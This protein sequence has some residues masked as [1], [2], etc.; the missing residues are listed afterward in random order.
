VAQYNLALAQGILFRSE[1]VTVHVREHVRSVVRFAKLL[2]LLCTYA[3][4]PKGTVLRV[5]GPLSLFRQTTK[6]GRA[7][8]SFLPSLLSTPG[9][10]IEAR[11]VLGDQKLR[12]LASA[13]DPLARPHAL[14]RA[15]DSKVEERLLRDVRKLGS[16]WTISRESAAVPLSDGGVFFPDFTLARGDDRV[17]VELV[18]FYTPEYLASK[19][20]ALRGARGRR[21]LVLV[22]EGL[23]CEDGAIT[24]DAV[25]RYRKRPDARALLEAAARVCAS[26]A[27]P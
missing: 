23:G 13:A 26:S 21:M 17:L 5:S 27:K 4:S 24:A 6:Y 11:C 25:L 14:P 15:T 18:G 3:E 9:W 7:L 10:E 1:E 12:F 2:R 8:A 19:L 22:D 20:R 16:E